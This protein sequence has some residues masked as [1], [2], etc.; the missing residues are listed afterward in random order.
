MKEILIA[1]CNKGKLREIELLLHG[2]VSRI[3]SPADFPPM[4]EVEENGETFAANAVL[5]ARAAFNATGLPV[6]ADDSGLVVDALGGRPGVR[7]ARFAGEGSSDGENNT[8]LLK[9][10]QGI[11]VENRTGSFCCV[12]AFCRE[13]GECITFDGELKGVILDEPKGRGGFGY[14]PLFLVPEYGRTVAELPMAIK[15][16][17][18][19]RGQAF[20]KMKR[21]LQN[22]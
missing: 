22:L 18:S 11:P 9:E 19:H 4:P 6:I 14:D 2:V 21:Y 8:L 5:K 3:C 15:N 20:A 10:M 13:N 17:I 12:V 16:A 7:S 1:T